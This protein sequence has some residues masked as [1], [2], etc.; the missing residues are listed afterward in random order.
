MGW[1]DAY[2]MALFF[3]VFVQQLGAVGHVLAH[4]GL[5]GRAHRQC[6]G[7]VVL[8]DVFVQYA[9]GIA[10]SLAGRDNAYLG[11]FADPPIVVFDGFFS[12]IVALYG[13]FDFVG[14]SGFELFE[15][16]VY[17]V[18]AGFEQALL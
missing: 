3:H 4:G 9:A 17:F 16:G 18:V 8:G 11:V 10:F 6:I 14:L 15:L 12:L 5:A 7:G 13:F 1:P 2:R